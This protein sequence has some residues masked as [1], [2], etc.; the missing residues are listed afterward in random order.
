MP[1]YSFY[2]RKCYAN[3]WRGFSTHVHPTWM[4]LVSFVDIDRENI[5]YGIP[6]T[7]EPDFILAL[8]VT[9]FADALRICSFAQ[10]WPPFEEIAKAFLHEMPFSA[11]ERKA[12]ETEGGEHA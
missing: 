1:Q 9:L 2:F 5:R 3:I 6:T 7:P 12:L 10:G 4:G 11:E 8:G